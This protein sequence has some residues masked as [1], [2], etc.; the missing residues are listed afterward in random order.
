MLLLLEQSIDV[1][2]DAIALTVQAASVKVT[3]QIEL[4]SEASAASAGDAL[5][6]VTPEA[7][8]DATGAQIESVEAPEVT[9]QVVTVSE[10]IPHELQD[11]SEEDSG[12]GAVIGGAAAG[13]VVALLGII[14]S[15]ALIA[16]QRK[17]NLEA[18]EA[19]P[20][21]TNPPTVT[22]AIEAGSCAEQEAFT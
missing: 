9:T 5:A 20:K 6:D 1:S 22:V 19:K 18:Q 14:A 10:D 3:A 21:K 12:R 7:L 8:S 15:S 11:S 4:A 17:R 2:P 16:R 13:A